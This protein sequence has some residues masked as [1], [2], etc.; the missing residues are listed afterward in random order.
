MK[1]RLQSMPLVAVI[2]FLCL[3]ECTHVA[4]LVCQTHETDLHV[5][6]KCPVSIF[7]VIL[8]SIVH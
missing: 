6:G 2:W 4:Y 5:Q 8:L 1:N 3:H 7:T